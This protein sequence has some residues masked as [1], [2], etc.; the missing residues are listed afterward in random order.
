M[1][2]F[3]RFPEFDKFSGEKQPWRAPFWLQ[4]L[5]CILFVAVVCVVCPEA[6]WRVFCEEFRAW[7]S[8]DR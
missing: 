1:F 2:R 4:A 5:G 3:D 7:L 6:A 8:G